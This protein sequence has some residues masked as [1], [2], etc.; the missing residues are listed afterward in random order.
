MEGLEKSEAF[1]IRKIEY[2][3]SCYQ[4]E[5]IYPARYQLIARANLKNAAGRTPRVQNAV[6]AALGRLSKRFD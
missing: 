3:E 4:E 2:V 1:S 6:T 5:G